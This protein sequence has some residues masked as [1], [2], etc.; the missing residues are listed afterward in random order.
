MSHAHLR[1]SGMIVPVRDRGI[2]GP[3]MCFKVSN[4]QHE[5]GLPPATAPLF[6]FQPAFDG[7]VGAS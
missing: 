4:D 6:A 7:S 5:N 1:C 2:E 3:Y